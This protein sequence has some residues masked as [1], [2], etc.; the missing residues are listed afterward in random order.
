MSAE[1]APP[2]LLAGL[3]AQTRLA[4]T[5][6][7]AVSA[8]RFAA[9]VRQVAERIEATMPGCRHVLNICS[10]RY[11]F[12]VGF[13][14]AL[15]ADRI[16]L[17][18]SSQTGE[19]VRQM[20]DFAPDLFCIEDGGESTILIPPDLPALNLATLG[21]GTDTADGKEEAEPLLP[22]MPAEQIAAYVFTSGSTGMPIPHRKTWGRLVRN[23]AAAIEQ[24]ELA[25]SPTTR[26]AI[27]ATVPPQHMYGFESSVLLNLLG[28][29]PI[30][31]GRPFYPADIVAALAAVPRPRMLVTTPFH[32]RTLL[33]AGVEIPPVDRIL[34]ATA[35][36]PA[37]LAEQAEAALGAPV[38]EIYG[39]TET[40]QIATRRITQSPLWSLMRDIQLRADDDGVIASGGHIEGE[41]RLGDIIEQHPEGRFLLLGRHTDLINIAGKR[42]TLGY[43][44][45]QLLA[46]AGVEDGCFYMPDDSKTDQSAQITRLCAIVAAPGLSRSTLLAALR[47]RIDAIFLPRPLILV[48]RLP[49]NSTGKLPR[50]AL[51]AIVAEHAAQAHASAAMPGAAPAEP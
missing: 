26:T 8:A 21:L 17:L 45:Q 49:R 22:A 9:D 18:P 13:A 24:L 33:D 20:R 12:I 16:S 50:T 38:H 7:G 2:P 28:H 31:S 39:C 1:P 15:L 10:D 32:L 4:F 14:A 30:W 41:I 37:T 43:L 19:T 47:Q 44:N 36:L 40:G 23:A 29:C 34:S 46:I 51:T 3:P 35:P 48:E 5:A 6:R 27:V 11:R 25:S 42:T